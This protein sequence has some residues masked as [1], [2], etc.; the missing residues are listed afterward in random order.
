MMQASPILVKRNAF[1]LPS[2]SIVNVVH[3]KLY[4]W[5]K[6]AYYLS[7]LKETFVHSG[8]VCLQLMTF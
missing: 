2:A 5:I 1:C 3:R 6:N 7:R 8:K 4:K